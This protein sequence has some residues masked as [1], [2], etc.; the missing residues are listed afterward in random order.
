[1]KILVAVVTCHR[2]RSHVSIH[3]RQ[4]GQ[5]NSRT[6]VIRQT[7]L[8]HPRPDNTDIRFFFGYAPPGIKPAPDEIFL[9]V[10][11]SYQGILEKVRGIFRYAL[12]HGYDYVLRVDDDVYVDRMTL[13]SIDTDNYAGSF[14]PLT[15]L[16]QG[17]VTMLE[18]KFDEPTGYCSGG[19]YSVSRRSMEILTRTKINALTTTEC[20]YTKDGKPGE[21][22]G[23]DCLVLEDQ[24]VGRQLREHKIVMTNRPDYAGFTTDPTIRQQRIAKHE[25]LVAECRDLRTVLPVQKN[26]VQASRMA[27]MSFCAHFQLDAETMHRLYDAD[28]GTVTM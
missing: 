26:A 13:S 27:A 5:A 25:G 8:N 28:V 16:V 12:D 1:M 3:N 7:W 19:C 10:P 23:K 17:R 4:D 14:S 22:G 21:F 18:S 15:T 11:D 9:S 6:G 2:F 20:R 24:W